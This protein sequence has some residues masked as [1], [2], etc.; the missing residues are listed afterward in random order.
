MQEAYKAGMQADI[1]SLTV[2]HLLLG[3]MCGI[4]EADRVLPYLLIQTFFDPLDV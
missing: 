4:S 1:L 2:V 3:T